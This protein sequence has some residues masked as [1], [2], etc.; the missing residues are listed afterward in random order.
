LDIIQK[1]PGANV[2]YIVQHRVFVRDTAITIDFATVAG[3]PQINGIEIYY[4]G[5]A[6]PTPTQLPVTIHPT[7]P[8]ITLPPNSRPVP[9]SPPGMFQDILIN[10]GGMY[11]FVS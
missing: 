2:S 4:V 1:A 11:Q 5:D 8:P 10:C 7:P 6:L 9:V 3:D